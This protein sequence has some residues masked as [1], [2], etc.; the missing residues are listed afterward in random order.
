M[1]FCCLFEDHSILRIDKTK[2]LLNAV[3]D[4]VRSASERSKRLANAKEHSDKLALSV[5]QIICYLVFVA[6]FFLKL[7]VFSVGV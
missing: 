6:I 2:L 4:D 5:I 3:E 7:L 1:S